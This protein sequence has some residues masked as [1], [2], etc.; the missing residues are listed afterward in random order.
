VP[1]VI[2]KAAEVG[3]DIEVAVQ[4]RQR[5]DRSGAQRAGQSADI[6]IIASVLDDGV[7]LPRRLRRRHRA[8]GVFHRVGQ[9]LFA[10]NVVALLQGCH[11]DLRVRL[12]YCAVEHRVGPCRV[13]DTLQIGVDHDITGSVIGSPGPR[14]LFVHVDETHQLQLWMFLAHLHPPAT[15]ATTAHQHDPHHLRH[16]LAVASSC[17]SSSSAQ[18][19]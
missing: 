12:G 16:R 8:P 2:A 5:T 9:W 6:G 15:H 3:A 7:D 19:S 11:R 14:R 18:R 4:R 10:Q 17:C 1:H 13:E